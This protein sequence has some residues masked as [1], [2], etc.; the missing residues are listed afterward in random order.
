MIELE[1]QTSVAPETP[2][3]APAGSDVAVISHIQRPGCV[4]AYALMLFLGAGLLTLGGIALGGSGDIDGPA[5]LLFVSLG[6]AQLTIAIGLWRMRWWA[7]RLLII[8]Q[9]IGV[10]V[11]LIS[12][13]SEGSV[14]VLAGVAINIY[15]ISWF[16]RNDRQFR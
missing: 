5:V 16:A 6:V 4:T 13:L 9:G 10:A 14:G 8:V 12:L 1:N 2:G 7:P 11:S 3:A 15:L